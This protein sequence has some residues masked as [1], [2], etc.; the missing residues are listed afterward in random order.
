MSFV[1]SV[2]TYGMSTKQHF[3]FIKQTVKSGITKVLNYPIQD[4]S[5]KYH[6]S[7][8]ARKIFIEIFYKDQLIAV[9]T[10]KTFFSDY[11]KDFYEVINKLKE[12]NQ[13]TRICITLKY[14]HSGSE[15]NDK[16]VAEVDNLYILNDIEI[17]EH[18]LD[19]GE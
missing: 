17:N 19:R 8:Y 12:E 2:Q 3:G 11:M 15:K 16:R 1:Y 10:N 18:L 4:I 6:D 5:L 13:N 7:V 14:W 9:K